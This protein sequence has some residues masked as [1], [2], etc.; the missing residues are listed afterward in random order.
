MKR[1]EFEI[2]SFSFAAA[3]QP[4]EREDELEA[5]SEFDEYEEKIN[6]HSE[7]TEELD[8]FDGKL[9]TSTYPGVSC[10]TPGN[11][12]VLHCFPPFTTDLTIDH[13]KHLGIIAEKIRQSFSTNRLA[14]AQPITKVNIVGHS[15]TWHDQSISD[16]E[17]NARDRANNT[18]EEL[19]RRLRQIGLANRVNVQAEGRSDTV[20]W[21]GKSYSSTKGD[22]QAQ[23]DRAVN[24]RVEIKLTGIGTYTHPFLG[25]GFAV[26]SFDEPVGPRQSE[27]EGDEESSSKGFSA[28]QRIDTT[29]VPFRWI[30]RL[31][32]FTRDPHGQLKQSFSSGTLI[33]PK[34]VLTAAHVFD[35]NWK[36]P[37]GKDTDIPVE[38]LAINVAPGADGLHLPFSWSKAKPP[39]A[40]IPHPKWRSSGFD[41]RFDVGLIR[42]PHPIG[43]RTFRKL[44]KKALGCWGCAPDDDGA[45]FYPIEFLPHFGIRMRNG[46]TVNTCGYRKDGRN[47][48]G[49]P[50][51]LRPVVRSVGPTAGRHR[52]PELMT[53]DAD[54]SEGMSGAPV[55]Y[56][57]ERAKRRHLI[58]VHHGDCG[59]CGPR[60]ALDDCKMRPL[61]GGKCDADPK[62]GVL[63]KETIVSDIHDLKKDLP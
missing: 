44:N 46:A 35:A 50:T 27:M 18:R 23:N 32:V 9:E 38:V 28:G 41:P 4:R 22:R 21:L 62:L 3:P 8:E 57:N 48:I 61:P 47:G 55:W 36:D 49:R 39:G 29:K 15:A 42:L 30:C 40:W 25:Q 31:R 37:D 24:R 7:L 58:A 34:H 26:T 10:V 14:R 16:R 13:R 53:Y 12:Y 52:I 63:L 6:S 33:G 5:Y 1:N 20:P 17:R 60:P 2:S 11:P 45:Y 59:N 43:N 54:T 51:L 19:I 56:W